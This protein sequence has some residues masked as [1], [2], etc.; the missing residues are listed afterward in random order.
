MRDP[1]AY[2]ISRFSDVVFWRQP[3]YLPDTFILSQTLNPFSAAR[4]S[5]Q[6]LMPCPGNNLC[7][8][9]NALF[10]HALVRTRWVCNTAIGNGV[11]HGFRDRQRR[12]WV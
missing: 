8:A 9:V 1:G 12:E 7:H 2:F 4:S 10:R 11:L 6:I 5:G 3:W